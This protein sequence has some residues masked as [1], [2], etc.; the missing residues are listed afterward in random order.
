VALGLLFTA[1]GG[2]GAV[3]PVLPTTPFLLL[4]SF[5]FIRSSPALHAWLLRSPLFGP[6]LADW[7]C[8]RA[9]R[10]RV[11]GVSIAMVL[12]AAGAS[13]WLGNLPRRLAVVLVVL[14][15]IGVAVILRLPTVAEQ[16]APESGSRVE[17]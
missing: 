14:V 9:V 2:L 6:L 16:P 13:L 11:K 17:P 8:H 1:L 10:K 7:H 15:A 12:V 3:L 4:A 5:F